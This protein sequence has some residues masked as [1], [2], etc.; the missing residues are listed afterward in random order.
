MNPFSTRQA[1]NSRPERVPAARP[2]RAARRRPSDVWNLRFE[3]V[4]ARIPAAAVAQSPTLLVVAVEDI[5]WRVAMDQCKAGRPH[6][7]R[8]HAYA[9]WVAQAR[10]LEDKR[11]RLRDLV[12][13]ELLAW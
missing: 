9:A 4:D 8:R 3:S 10:R 6:R 5:C 7:W 12:D 1:G 2:R 13:G 11:D